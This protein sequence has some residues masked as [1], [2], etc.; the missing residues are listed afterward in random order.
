ML[1]EIVV[2]D[3]HDEG[4]LLLV[5]HP[6]ASSGRASRG[7]HIDEKVS[8]LRSVPDREDH[9][10]VDVPDRRRIS[11]RP[12]S[13]PSLRRKLVVECPSAAFF[14]GRLEL[15]AP[16]LVFLLGFGVLLLP[17]EELRRDDDALHARRRLERRILHVAGLLAEDRLEQFLFGRRIRFTLRR[18]LADQDVAFEDLGAD[19]DDAVL[20]EVLRRPLRSRSGS[21]A[22]APPRLA[23]CRGPGGRTPRCGSR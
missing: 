1:L 20:V 6:V 3:L 12:G 5:F 15:V 17:A 11:R 18:D 8:A 9:L 7:R 19:P 16:P 14:C 13:R 2:V 4:V 22:S 10:A 21:P 23:S